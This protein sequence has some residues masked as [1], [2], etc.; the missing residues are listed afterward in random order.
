MIGLGKFALID[1]DVDRFVDCLR[2]YHETEM[3]NLSVKNKN[4]YLEIDSDKEEDLEM[5]EKS[6]RS[7]KFK[8]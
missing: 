4:Y 6:L 7:Y 3:I 2:N 1:H 5:V 8:K